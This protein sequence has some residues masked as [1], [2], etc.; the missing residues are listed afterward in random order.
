[1]IRV[2]LVTEI[3]LIGNVIA[4]VLQEESDIQVIGTVTT[5]A[6]AL[7]QAANADV[8]LVSPRLPNDGS[9]QLISALVQHQPSIKV[10]A[11]GLSESKASV[12]QFVEAGA[13]GYVARDDS[14]EDLL[15]R[16]RAAY[17]DKAMV[18]PEI[19]AALM[20]RV[21]KYAQL[22]T[23]IE[24]GAYGDTGLTPR[25]REILQLIAQGLTNQEIAD[26]LVIEV[27]TVKNHVHNILQKLDVSNR[28]EAAAFL[29][30]LE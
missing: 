14:V 1:M 24:A 5:A 29:S 10:L 8:V 25:E 7:A 19:A 16:I 12:L 30:L 23:D 17:R 27:G 11:L 15:E 26:R 20:S 9:L 21:A 6:Q 2:L 4:N 28:E 3:Q 22:F 13:V 18:S